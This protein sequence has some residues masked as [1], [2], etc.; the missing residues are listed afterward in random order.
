MSKSKQAI[1]L[2]VIEIENLKIAGNLQPF[3]LNDTYAADLTLI[4]K[5]SG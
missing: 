4:P 5:L 3:I 1:D 2:S